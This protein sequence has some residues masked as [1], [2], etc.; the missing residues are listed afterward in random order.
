MNRGYYPKITIDDREIKKENFFQMARNGRYKW[1]N[2]GI[3]MKNHGDILR[4][5]RVKV[6]RNFIFKS[7]NL[8][9]YKKYSIFV[10][11]NISKISYE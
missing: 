7:R 5:N 6:G 2:R 11:Q 9:S 3:K 4:E 10:T 8:D 1:Q